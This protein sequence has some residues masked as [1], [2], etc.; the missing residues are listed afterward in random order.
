MPDLSAPA[1]GSTASSSSEVW[2]RE[3]DTEYV[4]PIAVS[5]PVSTKTTGE[6][7]RAPTTA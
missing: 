5:A 4:R 1:I 2:R 7:G 6:R 3:F